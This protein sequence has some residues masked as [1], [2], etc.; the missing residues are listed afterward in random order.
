MTLANWVI[1]EGVLTVDCEGYPLAYVEQ[2]WGETIVLVHGSLSDYR[3]WS[4][5]LDDLRD[6]HRVIAVSLRHCFPE[7]WDGRGD[8]FSIG[9]HARDLVWF[10]RRFERPV[11]LVGF[12]RG[13]VVSVEA[14]RAHPELFDRLVLVEPG[15]FSVLARD[16]LPGEDP[17]AHVFSR[18]TALAFLC[19]PAAASDA[20]AVDGRRERS[21]ALPN[22]P[23]RNPAMPA[24]F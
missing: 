12:S 2:G 18:A 24:R 10:V 7:P 22:G 11:T 4:P 13:G 20:G 21:R 16:G 19:R 23:G 1:P 17:A 3:Y 14:A 5:Q 6:R 8:G 15:L 9:Q